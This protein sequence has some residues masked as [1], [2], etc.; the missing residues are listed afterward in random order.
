MPITYN[1]PNWFSP[2][3][4]LEM[5]SVLKVL[6][7][8][9]LPK[10]ETIAVIEAVRALDT[11]EMDLQPLSSSRQLEWWGDGTNIYIMDLLILPPLLFIEIFPNAARYSIE[12]F[13]Q[14]PSL[15][16]NSD[17]PL[18]LARSLNPRIVGE[19]R[20][21]SISCIMTAMQCQTVFRVLRLLAMRRD[22][23]ASLALIAMNEYWQ[24]YAS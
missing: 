19:A 7:S 17:L 15:A 1:I 12:I 5:E 14:G 8:A 18:G 4:Q 2:E 9:F 22:E 11:C 13:E 6:D 16:E 3:Y 20:I 23:A 10:L 21:K 24:K